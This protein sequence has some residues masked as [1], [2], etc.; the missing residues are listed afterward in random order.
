MSVLNWAAAQVEASRIAVEPMW[1]Q[2]ANIRR[3]NHR[4]VLEAFRQVRVSEH[5]LIGTTGYGYNDPSREVL[6][7]IYARIFNAEAALV[8]P[9][10]I[11]GTHAINLCLKGICRPGDEIL[12]IT[13]APYD[14]L[15]R[16]ISGPGRCLADW[17]ITYRELPLLPDGS[18]DIPALQSAIGPKTRLVMLQRSRGYDIRPAL[19]AEHIAQAA[20]TIKNTAPHVVTFVDNCYGEFVEKHEPTYYPGVDLLAGSLI[21]NPGGTLAPSGGYIVGQSEFVSQVADALTAPGLGNKVGPMLGVGRQLLQG[22]YLAPLFVAEA[23]CGAILAAHVFGELGY[24]TLPN[25]QAPRYDSVQTVILEKPEAVLA[26]CRAVQSAS[27]IDSTAVPIPDE[28]PGYTDPV[29]M[30]A[31]TFIQGASSEL[32]ADGPMRPPYAVFLQG[33]TARD[34]MELALEIALQNL[35]EAQLLPCP[36]SLNQD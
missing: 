14:T 23:V 6:E 18:C 33:G 26:V 17:G 16:I 35:A 31:G 28:L 2:I 9:Q 12:S 5:H 32:S 34:Q 20:A 1:Q 29:I 7:A 24:C 25:W 11:S 13:G 27:P 21:K 10:I 36:I 8:R 19:S 3:Y 4:R 15:R 30:A 22:L